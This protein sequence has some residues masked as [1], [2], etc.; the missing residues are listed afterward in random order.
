M[1]LIS[2]YNSGHVMESLCFSFII[3][4][5]MRLSYKPVVGAEH[6]TYRKMFSNSIIISITKHAVCVYLAALS[7]IL[8][9]K[10][11]GKY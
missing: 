6:R 3:C 9:F 5:Q 8:L 7:G 4:S 1:L 11:L 10:T 2:L